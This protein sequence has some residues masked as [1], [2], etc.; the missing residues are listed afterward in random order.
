MGGGG[1][2]PPI[3]HRGYA[4]AFPPP[5]MDKERETVTGRSKK[6]KSVLLKRARVCLCGIVLLE[7]YIKNLH[8]ITRDSE[9]DLLKYSTVL[10]ENNWSFDEP[11]Q[12]KLRVYLLDY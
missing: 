9:I 7:I 2:D 1:P 5:V 11:D 10:Y 3:P 6:K 12:A 8:N 4:T